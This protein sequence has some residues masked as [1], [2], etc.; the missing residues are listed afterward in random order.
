MNEPGPDIESLYIDS[1]CLDYPLVQRI[2]EK[3]PDVRVQDVPDLDAFLTEFQMQP[4]PLD[5]GKRSL[6]LT[7]QRG[8]FIK[9]C[10]CTPGYLCCGYFV[11]NLDLN[12]PLDCTY[13]ILQ[14]YLSNPLLTIHVNTH[15]LWTQLDNFLHK[16][17]G[18]PLRIGTGELGDSLVLDP[19]TDRSRELI[20]Y[21][22]RHPNAQLELKT[23][24]THIGRILET[25]PAPNIVIA[26][27]LNADSAAASEEEGAPDVDSRL[28]AA[29]AVVKRG[30]RVGFHFDPLIR[31][32]GWQD[33]Y[34]DVIDRLF[35]R[36]PAER[37]AWISLGALRFPVPLKDIIKKR[38][39]QTRILYEEFIRGLDGKMRY[40]KPHRQ[41]ILRYVA[42]C[43]RGGMGKRQIPLYL[44][45]ESGEL[46]R[47]VLKKEPE[48]K[49]EIERFLS[50]PSGDGFT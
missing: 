15:D 14:L 20:S 23:K 7:R 11:I 25:D 16:Q 5:R 43:L 22:R 40:F 1:T 32:P 29:A 3:L 26:W 44:C 42:E 12:C 39:P 45:M 6:L 13:C 37:I 27:S 46:W 17:R 8:D 35:A 19:L 31:F 21:F 47:K 30:Y 48:G 28:G 18:R 36:V 9:P 10:P 2:R 24:S 50:S 49:E 33:G 34:R 41:E 4:H 38:H